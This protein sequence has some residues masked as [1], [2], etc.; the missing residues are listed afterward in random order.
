MLLPDVDNGKILA[1]F[2]DDRKF[3]LIFFTFWAFIVIFTYGVISSLLV[4][5]L[6]DNLSLR[7][8]QLYKMVL[9]IVFGMLGNLIIGEVNL[10]SP[11]P[12]VIALIFFGID[13]LL[14]AKKKVV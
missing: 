5:L 3:F 13:E 9:Y 7:F 11:I 8:A 2:N 10:A 14:L 4:D 1:D 12:V 6:I